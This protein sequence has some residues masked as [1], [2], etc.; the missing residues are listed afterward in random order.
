MCDFTETDM[1]VDD[2]SKALSIIEPSQLHRT[3]RD[4][5]ARFAVESY[6]CSIV[7]TLVHRGRHYRRPSYDA[8]SIYEE[9]WLMRSSSPTCQRARP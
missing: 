9:V 4:R 2:L 1:V 5:Q 3:A 6:S 8:V 7:R